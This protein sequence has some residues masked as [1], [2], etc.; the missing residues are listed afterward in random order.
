M[1]QHPYAGTTLSPSLEPWHTVDYCQQ[2]TAAGASPV[3]ASGLLYAAGLQAPAPSW[4]GQPS[5]PNSVQASAVDEGD[6]NA[7]HKFAQDIRERGTVGAVCEAVKQN[8]LL[9]VPGGSVIM[10]AQALM[11]GTSD[12]RHGGATE[13]HAENFD[14]TNVL[15]SNADNVGS[16]VMSA[17]APTA[18]TVKSGTDWQL[19]SAQGVLCHSG[20]VPGHQE[21]YV[22]SAPTA[23][24]TVAQA[25]VESVDLLGLG[26]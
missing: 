26:S 8:P 18:Q 4:S 3:G 20:S 22:P 21:A 6:R 19:P 16:N 12:S 14:F 17:H 15:A 24:V 13:P 2:D 10:A 1:N 11:G 5:Q 9:L 25:P 23:H 7:L